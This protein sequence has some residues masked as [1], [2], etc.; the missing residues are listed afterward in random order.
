MSS[1][2]DTILENK[3]ILVNGCMCLGLY[4]YFDECIGCSGKSELCCLKYS[5][6][7]KEGANFFPCGGTDEADTYLACGCALCEISCIPIQV[8]CK[9][10]AQFCCFVTQSTIPPD[11]EMPMVC[12]V[13][14]LACLPGYGCCRSLLE[15]QR[16]DG[17]FRT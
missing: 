16:T 1:V 5:W 3:L 8:C 14:G 7:C 11:N 6:C 9:H 17:Y 4:I 2:S 10:Q 15:L 12:A 13:L